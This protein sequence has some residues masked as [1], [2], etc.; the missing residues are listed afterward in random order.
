MRGLFGT[1][2][3]RPRGAKRPDRCYALVFHSLPP[4]VT[5]LDA[6]FSCINGWAYAGNTPTLRSKVGDDVEINVYGLDDFFHT[7]HMHGHRWKDPSGKDV[8]DPSF[9]PGETVTARFVE[10]N[11]GRWLYHC[12]VFSHMMMG[13]AGW[14]VVS[15]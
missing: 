4:N 9:G 6:N 8:D 1:I 5:G 7:F 13:M 2:I 3:I 15:E 10:D 11:P 14:Y 12:H